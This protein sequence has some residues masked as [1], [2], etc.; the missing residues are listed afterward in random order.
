MIMTYSYPR[1]S[2]TRP[3]CAKNTSFSVQQ[4]WE[5]SAKRALHIISEPKGDNNSRSSVKIE[6]EDAASE[7]GDT[8]D[9]F[10]EEYKLKISKSSSTS[11]LQK[12]DLS[13][14]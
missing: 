10:T 7:L 12:I 4:Q 6:Y 11:S 2:P 13:N 1:D 8:S 9:N 5:S 3:T 14:T